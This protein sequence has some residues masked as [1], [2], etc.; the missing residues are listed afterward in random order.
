MIQF[1][2]SLLARIAMPLARVLLFI[3]FGLVASLAW[4]FN[5]L[6][7][8]DNPEPVRMIIKIFFLGALITIPVFAVEYILSKLITVVTLPEPI[9]LFLYW[10]VI[11]AFTEEIFKYFLLRYRVLKSPA[12]DEPVDAMIYMIIAAL[13]FAALE[14]ILYLIP[15]TEQILSFNALFTRTITI[16]F[17]RFIG[18]TFLH[19]LCSGLIGYFVALSICRAKKKIR[20][21][22]LGIFIAV[23]LHGL[24][25]FSIM[26]IEGSLKLAIP[27]LMLVSLAIFVTLGF[28]KLKTMESVCKV[29]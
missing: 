7:K 29:K 19:A 18:A 27:I 11:I 16:S 2:V 17:F 20:L 12:F 9:Y 3:F 4:L 21:T 28:K 24:Y 10:F 25:N 8:D 13:G 6:R 26:N 15:G 22:L 1:L 23:L 14:N 5:F